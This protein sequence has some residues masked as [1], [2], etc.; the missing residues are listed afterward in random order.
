MDSSHVAEFANLFAS[1]K[2]EVNDIKT[3]IAFTNKESVDN[4]S[5]FSKYDSIVIKMDS[6][7]S[8]LTGNESSTTE[9]KM[10]ELKSNEINEIMDEI[11]NDIVAQESKDNSETVTT[12]ATSSTTH[13]ESNVESNPVLDKFLKLSDPIRNAISE[14]VELFCFLISELNSFFKHQN[15]TDCSPHIQNPRKKNAQKT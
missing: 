9:S 10:S 11:D 13:S 12:Q 5:L 4:E 2:S 7:L 3:Q 8:K 6:I 14:P 1:L 15:T